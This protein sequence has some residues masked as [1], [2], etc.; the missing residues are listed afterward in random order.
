MYDRLDSPTAIPQL[1]KRLT[2]LE[3][4]IDAFGLTSNV[5][6][7]INEANKTLEDIIEDIEL[8][9]TKVNSIPI[10]GELVIKRLTAN[11]AINNTWKSFLSFTL[12][13]GTWLVGMRARTAT[14]QS[15]STNIYFNISNTPAQAWNEVPLQYTATVAT[16]GANITKPYEITENTPFYLNGYSSQSAQLDTNTTLWAIRIK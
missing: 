9:K 16:M 4:K 7:S 1:E 15:S 10:S 8:L 2:A 13:A 6:K 12:T 11:T 14:T 3:K 5:N